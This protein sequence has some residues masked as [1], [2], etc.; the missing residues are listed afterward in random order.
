MKEKNMSLKQAFYVFNQ[1][2][3]P[4]PR[5]KRSE[6]KITDYWMRLSGEL[7]DSQVLAAAASPLLHN[8]EVS[9][10]WLAWVR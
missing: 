7:F 6:N 4:Q 2:L 9:F 3:T 8:L 1:R 10:I 5:F